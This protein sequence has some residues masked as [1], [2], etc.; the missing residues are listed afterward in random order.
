M[1]PKP[2]ERKALVKDIHE[3][4]GHFSEGKTLAE[5]KKRFFWHER[6]KFVK[7]MVRQCQDCQ[8]VKSSG[9]VTLGIEKMKNIPVYD[10]FYKV[11]LDT[12]GPLPEIKDGSKYVVVAI[13]HYSKWCEARRVKD[14]DVSIVARFLEKEII[15]KFGVPRF[16]LMDNG[17]EWMAKFDLMCKKYGITHQFITPQWLHCNGMVEKMIKTLKNGLFVVSYINFDNWDL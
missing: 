17:G 16:I 7:T 15:C 3:K 1:V 14:H 9:N 4:I 2:K 11:A 8:L 5:I 6:T 12:I 10:L 13:D